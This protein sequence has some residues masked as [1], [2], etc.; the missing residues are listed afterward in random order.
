[1]HKTA[2]NRQR[3]TLRAITDWCRE[4]RHQPLDQQHRQLCRKLREHYAYYG[5]TG[6]S[7]SITNVR[8]KVLHIWY[9]WLNRRSRGGHPM[10]WE[11]FITLI[12]GPLFVPQARIVH[13]RRAANSNSEEPDARNGHVRV[14]GG[15][16]GAI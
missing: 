9:K 8:H 7:R 6:N 1:M 14:C 16:L 2:S 11:R 4:N 10:T 3:R 5:I 15:A 12:N 13:S